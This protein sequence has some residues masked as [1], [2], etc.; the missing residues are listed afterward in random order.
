MISTSNILRESTDY[1]FHNYSVYP[2]YT[3]EANYTM[4]FALKI[5]GILYDNNYDFQVKRKDSH[6][7]KKSLE[8]CQLYIS[9]I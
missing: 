2:T 9:I 8:F 4:L 3:S 7:R 1:L 5:K 6:R